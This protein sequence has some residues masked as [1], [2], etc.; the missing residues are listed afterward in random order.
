MIQHHQTVKWRE[1]R[2]FARE[3]LAKWPDYSDHPAKIAGDR[4]AELLAKLREA[5]EQAGRLRA[6]R[7]KHP[8]PPIDLSYLDDLP[9][10]WSRMEARGTESFQRFVDEHPE[11]GG[12]EQEATPEQ[13]SRR[14][15]KPPRIDPM[16]TACKMVAKNPQ[17]TV[18]VKPSGDIEISAASP[19]TEIDPELDAGASDDVWHAIEAIRGH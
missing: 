14:T 7:A 5:R 10:F 15:R 1:A 17:L 13:V 18:R 12:D 3:A 11:Y 19:P 2:E 9:A 6:A 4:Q 8:L 16:R